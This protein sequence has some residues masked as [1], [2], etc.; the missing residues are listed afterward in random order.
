MKMKFYGI[1]IFAF[2]LSGCAASLEDFQNMNAGERA[3]Y[4]CTQ[5]SN[6]KHINNS[7]NRVE[8]LIRDSRLIIAN[9]YRTHKSCNQVPSVVPITDCYGFTNTC[10]TRTETVYNTVC[11]ENPV[12]I[13]GD[14]EKEKLANYLE[15][16]TTLHKAYEEKYEECHR[17]LLKMSSKEAFDYYQRMLSRQ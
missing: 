15:R 10:T 17:P 13:D 3:S 11:Q 8:Y 6:I 2:L 16:Q 4:I 9:G 12:A 14:L 7:I 5:H 1:M